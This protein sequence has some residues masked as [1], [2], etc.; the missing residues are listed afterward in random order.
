MLIFGLLVTAGS[1]VT[2]V[3]LLIFFCENV[4]SVLGATLAAKLAF[5]TG[6]GWI[7]AVVSGLVAFAC[8]SV[9]LRL[10][11]GLV[12]PWPTRLCLTALIV[13]PAAI[14]TFVVT[15]RMLWPAVPSMAWRT[16][17]ASFAA[18]LIA[19]GAARKLFALAAAS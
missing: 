13:L 14:T 8:L 9:S 10:A 16:L 17:M 18:I 15:E 12:K 11:F 19:A 7:G 4:L 2:F 6:G 5:I 1:L 3:Y